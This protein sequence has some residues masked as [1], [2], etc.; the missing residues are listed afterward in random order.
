MVVVGQRNDT[1]YSESPFPTNPD[2]SNP[3]RFLDFTASTSTFKSLIDMHGKF[4]VEEASSHGGHCTDQVD[5]F[6]VA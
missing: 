5:I 6:T 4:Q 1:G 3:R 2:M